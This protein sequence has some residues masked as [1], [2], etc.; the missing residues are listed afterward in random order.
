MTLMEKLATHLLRS[1]SLFTVLLAWMAGLSLAAS[2]NGLVPFSRLT[3]D[4]R[5]ALEE[6]V[7]GPT[8][9]REVRG[10]K[11]RSRKEV[12]EYLL[13]HPDF[14]AAVAR[15]FGL[16]EYQI[17]K[18]VDVVRASG[19]SYWGTDG[20]GVTGHFRVVYA[21]GKKRVFFLDGTL[22]KKWLP[23][24][25][26]R[27]VMV[28]I[29]EYKANGEGSYVENDLYGYIKIDNTFVAYLVKLLQPII[30]TMAHEKIK[31]ILSVGATVSE[32]AYR[33]PAGFLRKL[34]ESPE[35]SRQE[36]DGFRRTFYVNVQ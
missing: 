16:S 18:D 19:D 29:F 35:L 36:L 7:R 33:D 30:G 12:Y 22:N 26:A 28:L 31:H 6:V 11:F 2:E 14:A 1:S 25:F 3:R 13:N 9:S 15:A 34:E 5:Q 8:L 23:T 10:V 32:L 20:A 24:I 27:S 21:D 17:V 4:D